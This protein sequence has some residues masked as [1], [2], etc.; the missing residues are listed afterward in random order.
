MTAAD[1][2]SGQVVDTQTAREFTEQ[3]LSRVGRDELSDVAAL[4]EH[5]VQ[6]FQTLLARDALRSL[7]EAQ[8]TNLL[9]SV[10][11]T[12]RKHRVILDTLTLGGFVDLCDDL[13]YGD[14]PVAT[15]LAIF[16]NEVGGIGRDLPSQV[17]FDLGS[18]LLHFSDPERYWLWTQWMWDPRNLTGS[19]PL[20]VTE[21]V[22]LIADDIAETYR[23]IGVA[24]AFV[25]DVG[26]AAEFRE[27]G[28]GILDTDV[29]LACVY[30]IYMYTT[31]RM[32]MTQEFNQVVP[33]LG[34]LLR[35]LLGV[36]RSPLIEGTAP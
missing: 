9:R 27:R 33:E 11:S 21:E 7:T 15:R 36:H 1:F 2:Y 23:R 10:F 14:A 22:D 30:G 4:L 18:S 20:V 29:F 25:N 6:A 35:R 8:A 34:E 31:L 24:I 3:V 12:R 16:H 32:R 26:E 5:K 13:L 19:L 17:G 28:H